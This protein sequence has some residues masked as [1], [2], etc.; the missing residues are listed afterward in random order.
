[1]KPEFSATDHSTWPETLTLGQMA[2]IWQT[3]ARALTDRCSRGNFR[4]APLEGKPRRWSKAH[5]LRH[6]GLGN[7]PARRLAVSA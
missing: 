4:P 7:Q 3:T 5:V 6:L 2:A 1:M